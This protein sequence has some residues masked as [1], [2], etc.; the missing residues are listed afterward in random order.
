[1]VTKTSRSAPLYSASMVVTM[2]RPFNCCRQFDT[3]KTQHATVQVLVSIIN[4]V[5]GDE[6]CRETRQNSYGDSLLHKWVHP[7]QAPVRSNRLIFQYIRKYFCVGQGAPTSTR[8]SSV[9]RLFILFFFIATILNEHLSALCF[10]QTK[11]E[12]TNTSAL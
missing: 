8:T 12:S 11:I 7:F 1:M 5:D 9:M 4:A 2:A 3:K 10:R 6:C